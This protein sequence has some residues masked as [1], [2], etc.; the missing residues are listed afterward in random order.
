MVTDKGGPDWI[1]IVLAYLPYNSLE[2]R[3]IREMND[4]VRFFKADDANA[5][6]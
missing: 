2:S 3:P 1:V 6:I 4:P 5:H